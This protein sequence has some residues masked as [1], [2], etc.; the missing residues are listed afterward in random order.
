MDYVEYCDFDLGESETKHLQTLSDEVLR[1]FPRAG[2]MHFMIAGMNV[3][4][5]HSPSSLIRGRV[6]MQA[7]TALASRLVRQ[8]APG[9]DIISVRMLFSPPGSRAQAWHLD[10]AKHFSEVKTIFIAVTPSSAANC[11][12][13]LDLGNDSERICARARASKGPFQLPAYECKARIAPL[14][15]DQW[16]VCQLRT[17]HAFHRRGA[18]TSDYV[19]VTFNVDVASGAE[20]PNFKDL[21]LERALLGTR[22]I[23]QD[24]IDELEEQDV[25]LELCDLPLLENM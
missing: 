24:I 20:A 21:D 22:V 14:L 1:E 19:R 4:E 6:D 8:L 25:T 17:S 18:N 5:E 23:G 10:F 2:P 13:V 11:T 15:L 12:E 3:E 7:L 16:K 9:L